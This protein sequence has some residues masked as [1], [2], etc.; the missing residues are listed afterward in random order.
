MATVAHA[1]TTKEKVKTYLGLSGTDKDAVIDQIISG[2]TAF[3]E[4]YCGGRRFKSTSYTEIKDGGKT[5]LFLNQYPVTALTAVEYRSGG[6]PASPTWSTYDGNSYEP[7]LSEG[8]LKFYGRL[9]EAPRSM[10][11]TYTAGY[12]IDFTNEF[13]STHTLP[14]DL[15]LVA[16]EL[17]AKSVNNGPS[18]GIISQSTEG[19]T[20]Q[21]DSA[22]VGSLSKTHRNILDKYKAYRMAI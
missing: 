18:D 1:L 20:V 4:G 2:V 3:I 13:T 17:A 11:V 9:P 5:T 21:F 6:T 15:T 8:Y 22:T 19:Q 14:F 7:Y 12:L 16:T 10:R